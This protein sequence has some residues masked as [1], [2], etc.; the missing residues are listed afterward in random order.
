VVGDVSVDSFVYG[1]VERISPE[2]PIPVLRVQRESVVLGG[3][4][5][6]VQTSSRLWPRRYVGV[7]GHAQGVIQLPTNRVA[8]AS[9]YLYYYRRLAPDEIKTRFV[10]D[11]NLLRADREVSAALL[12]ETESQT[13]ARV[14]SAIDGCDVIILSDYAKGVLTDLVL[15]EI[16]KLAKEKNKP[17]LI[18]PKGRDFS[19]YHGAFMLTPNR[20]ELHEA[21][22]LRSNPSRRGKSGAAAYRGARSG[23]GSCE[24]GRRRRLPRRQGRARPSLP[25]DSPRSL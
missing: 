17:I 19:R 21:T 20:K 18:D 8:A 5:N 4:G 11:G 3:A 24:A 25:R 23:R 6:V 12:P 7:V 1:Q 13:L 16:I 2:A 10:R 22:G 9:R 15:K 14:H